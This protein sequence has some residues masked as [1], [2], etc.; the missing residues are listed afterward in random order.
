[1]PG[2]LSVSLDLTRALAAADDHGLDSVAE[3]WVEGEIVDDELAQEIVEEAAAVAA[4]AVRPGM[5]L[6]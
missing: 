1:L 2:V 4:G 5:S 6:Y 3:R